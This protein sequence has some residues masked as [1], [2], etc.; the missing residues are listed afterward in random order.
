MVANRN[1]SIENM[2]IQAPKL[3]PIKSDRI[4]KPVLAAA[5]HSHT[6]PLCTHS[7][8]HTV[9]LPATVLRNIDYEYNGEYYTTLKHH[10]PHLFH[11]PCSAALMARLSSFDFPSDSEH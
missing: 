8:H 10:N 6:H 9:R 2:L 3:R 7:P 1:S 4:P 5:K 11:T